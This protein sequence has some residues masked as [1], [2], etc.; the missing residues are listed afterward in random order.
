MFDNFKKWMKYN[1]P[2]SDTF[3]GWNNFEKSFKKN[4]PIRYFLVK[5][6]FHIHIINYIRWKII[7]ALYAI[8]YSITKPD[9][10]RTDLSRSYHDKP[11][12]MFHACFSLLVDY[13]EKECAYMNCVFGEKEK[14]KELM[15]WKR[16]LP[17]FLRFKPNRHKEFGLDY[18][19]WE[20]SLGDE[21]PYQA[22]N[23][24]KILKLYLWYTKIRP[25]RIVPECP[26]VLPKLSSAFSTEWEENNS[27]DYI[28]FK[29]WCDKTSRLETVW[30]EEDDRMLGTLI[31]IRDSL[32]T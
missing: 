11:E 29:E 13:V 2:V 10:V 20:I 25:N 19:K 1:P 30:R 7:D 6:G 24:K 32:W 22:E 23:A 18:L 9:I 8:K 15:G 31:E 12:L 4:A 26:V 17:Y 14:Q 16:F 5:D 27:E 28:R 3:E 21:S